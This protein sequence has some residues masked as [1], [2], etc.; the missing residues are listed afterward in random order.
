MMLMLLVMRMIMVMMFLCDVVVVAGP[1]FLRASWLWANIA[2]VME[3][4][5]PW[6]VGEYSRGG[7]SRN[8]VEVRHVQFFVPTYCF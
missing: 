7:G 8:A 5:T 1:A 2:E 4:E 6:V 3:A